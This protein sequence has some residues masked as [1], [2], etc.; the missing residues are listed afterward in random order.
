MSDEQLLALYLCTEDADYLR[1]QL[2][3]EKRTKKGIRLFPPE[4]PY[5]LEVGI[6][7][8]A[9]L[10]DARARLNSDGA[11]GSGRKVSR[12]P[13]ARRAH[14][15]LYWHGPKRQQ[16]IVRWLSLIL[17]NIDKGPIQPTIHPVTDQ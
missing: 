7:L 5:V 8:G 6:R 14:F 16:F 1:R 11:D 9:A 15:H 12:L 4:K 13:H 10:R 17:V 3:P 2:S